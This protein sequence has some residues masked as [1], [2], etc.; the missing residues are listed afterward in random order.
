MIKKQPTRTQTTRLVT[1]RRK[2]LLMLL[3]AFL[4]IGAGTI[5]ITAYASRTIPYEPPPFEQGAVIG[6]PVPPDNM[7]YNPISANGGYSFSMAAN[8]YQQENGDLCLYF[9]N[10]EDSGVWMMCEVLSDA[11]GTM[12][13]SGVL[14]PGEYVE[15]LSKVSDFPNEPIEIEIRVY[16]FEP[17][18]YQSKGT[19]YLKT[20]LQPW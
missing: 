19:V 14:R 15:R 12:Y 13:Q 18:T 16:G 7:S 9:T 3:G 17:D 5:A 11:Y 6:V 8:L 20:I 1:G 10:P 2:L 4:L